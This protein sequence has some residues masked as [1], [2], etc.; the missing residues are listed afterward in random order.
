M[1]ADL[2]PAP[3]PPSL[4]AAVWL[5]G[6]TQNVG[7]GTLYY[8]M[9]VLASDIAAEFRWP[10]AWVFGALSLAL[11]AGGFAAPFAGR[12]IDR[13]GAGT[14]MAVGSVLAAL[15]MAALAVAPGPAAFVAALIAVQVVST[16]VQYDAAFACLVQLAGPDAR[17]RITHLTLIAGFASTMFWPL[18]SWLH[19][20]LDWRGV[21]GLYAAM[22]L[23]LCGPAHLILAR[24]LRQSA[25]VAA[26]RDGSGPAVRAPAFEPAPLA[27]E[28]ARKVA[29]LVTVGFALGGF[30]LSGVLA[31]MVP[32]L[33]AVGLG[34]SAV[35]VST[36]FG[37]SQVLVRFVNM[38]AGQGAH[39]LTVT[40]IS[41][42][43]LTGAA[44][45][46]AA[47]APSVAGA[48]VFALMLGFGSGLTSIVR[49]TLPLAL[50]GSASYGER[51][52]R[53]AMV[54]LVFTSVSPFVLALLMEAWGPTAA[55]LAMAS[56][57]LLALA[58]FAAVGRMTA[59]H[60]S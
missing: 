49:G 19:T 37:P 20:V 35:L 44:V 30:V 25:R 21:I 40:M 45:I 1:P 56:T 29:L 43:L 17:R 26:A 13:H 6:L 7:Y 58:T 39:P 34:T 16:L 8:G 3:K 38:I 50:F 46:L 11:L 22:N 53:M 33:G 59:K 2:P 28:V 15:A 55:L 48:A 54:R 9:A 31:Q 32:L 23:L 18:T 5:L 14:V 36:L 57:G 42:G 51:L 41:S 24:M 12:R 27:P 10:V 4:A 60:R 47:T 52:G